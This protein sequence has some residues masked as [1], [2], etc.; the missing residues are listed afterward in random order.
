[1][2]IN[3]PS[4]WQ[5]HLE[6]IRDFLLVGK[7]V[8]WS[9]NENGDI[10]FLDAKGN[11]ESMETGP[12][13]HHFR[14][15]SFKSEE[16]YLKECWLKC[17]EQKTD[18]P[19]L[20]LQIEERNGNMVVHH[21]ANTPSNCL[22]PH[23]EVNCDVKPG[24]EATPNDINDKKVTDIVSS[25]DNVDGDEQDGLLDDCDVSFDN[26]TSDDQGSDTNANKEQSS[27]EE[28]LAIKD[29]TNA[30]NTGKDIQ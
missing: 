4:S 1:M 21:I 26:D 18:R 10:H 2:L 7:G 28:C 22:M 25:D 29:V 9:E 19:I 6:R 3:H 30:K 24:D 13:L 23:A 12:L 20:R 8:W 27:P 11:P 5:S 16:S 17:L 14:S 15:S